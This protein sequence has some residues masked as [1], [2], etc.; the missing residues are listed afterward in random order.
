MSAIVGFSA[1]IMC[2]VLPENVVREAAELLT[3]RN[4]DVQTA[5]VQR[6]RRSAAEGVATAAESRG[7]GCD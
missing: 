2:Q 1:G 7:P 5:T 3:T 6:E 4:S